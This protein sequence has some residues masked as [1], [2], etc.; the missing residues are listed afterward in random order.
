MCWFCIMK[1][2]PHSG[3]PLLSV[4][5]SCY[6][7]LVVRI[8]L[9]LQ[10]ANAVFTRNCYV[11]HLYLTVLTLQNLK[12][13]LLSP[14]GF[15]FLFNIQLL[16]FGLLAILTP[17]LSSSPGDHFRFCFPVTVSAT[18]RRVCENRLCPT[19]LRGTPEFNLILVLLIH[20]LIFCFLMQSF[21][22]FTALL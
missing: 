16:L 4:P 22:N 12:K 13:W 18:F 11:F 1:V 20:S 6:S 2:M 7:L 5:V 14:V 3:N 9:V 21:D 19:V 17:G 8:L 15:K 10:K